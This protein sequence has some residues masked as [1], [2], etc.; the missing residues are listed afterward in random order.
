MRY[1]LTID[2]STFSTK[3][4][5]IDEDSNIVASSAYR[6]QQY[7][8]QNGWVEHD[9]QEIYNN[10]LK[11]IKDL[12][13]DYPNLISQVS[14]IAITNQRE[15][16]ILWNKKTGQPIHHA[17][18]WQCRR[19]AKMCEELKQYNN[20]VE[21]LTGLKINPYFSATK[22]KWLLDH[23]PKQNDLAFGTMESW[24]IYKLTSGKCHV[25]DI[26][27]ASRTLLMNIETQEWDEQL[28]NIFEIPKEILPMI[29]NNDD[30]F[31]YSD[32]EGLLDQKVP[33][34]GVIGDS[35]GALYAQ[36]C[37]NQGDMKVTLGTGSSLMINVG[38]LKPKL[39]PGIVS[40]VA[41]KVENKIT[42]AREAIINCSC[43]TLNWL[44]DQ[45]K[46]FDNESQLNDIFDEVKNNDGV[47]L[48]PAF[49]GL[50]VPWWNDEARAC[51]SGLA[52]NHDYKYI[53]RAGLESIAYQIYDAAIALHYSNDQTL[54][55]DGGAV[56]NIG[57]LQFIADIL[58]I[59]VKVSYNYDLSAIGAYEI[60]RSRLFKN[61]NF[62]EDK[63]CYLPGMR[64][65]LRN[66]NISGW[67]QA[68][69]GVLVTANKKEVN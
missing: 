59:E 17:I 57:L 51:I 67:H 4:F 32:V 31:G 11:A 45:M 58:K 22:L 23:C 25:S 13:T 5:I 30:I 27:N 41:W 24:L 37:F 7:Y 39:E 64:D 62:N 19:T 14:A 46:L 28:C 15:T 34:C 49:V 44:R 65:E 36:H 1:I 69:N 38:E 56:E 18:V 3:V 42:Y 6:H 40:T 21:S 54:N 53:L 29:L 10:L 60:A 20:K 33:I 8:P 52:R 50:S 16:T 47:Y 55:I 35:Q 66:K 63:M 26:T 2:Q 68:I 12:K 48:V 61:N 9:A 43:D